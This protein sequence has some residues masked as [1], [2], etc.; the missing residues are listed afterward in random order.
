MDKIMN[1]QANIRPKV[2]IAYSHRDARW[3]DLLLRQLRVLER[4]KLVDLWDTGEIVPGD[5]WSRAISAAL[6]EA[7]IALLLLS[8]DF[9]ASDYIADKELPALLRRHHNDDL[10]VLPVVVTPAAWMHTPGLAEIQFLNDPSK[11]LSTLSEAERDAVVVAIVGRI[12]ELAEAIRQ[13]KAASQHLLARDREKSRDT[14]P[15]PASIRGAFFISHS[16]S[17]GDFAELLKLKLEQKGYVA[18][19]DTDRLGPGVDWRQE[20]D[21]AIKRSAAVIAIMSAEARNSEY[22]TYEW[23]FAWGAAIKVIPIMLQE[24][25]L[26]PRLATLQYLDFTNRIARPWDRLLAALE[27]IAPAAASTTAPAFR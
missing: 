7:D 9:L 1:D 20:I 6:E 22:V 11:P 4:Q 5:D 27:E 17:D 13:R 8:A 15:A 3:K 24:T 19:I 25:P 23:A 21:E 12:R 10:I 2:F 26:H 14:G 16:R 18:W